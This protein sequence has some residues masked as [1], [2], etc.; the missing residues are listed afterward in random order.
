M[1]KS[2]RGISPIY[3]NFFNSMALFFN[4]LLESNGGSLTRGGAGPSG[5]EF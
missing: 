3:S 1:M 4:L 2:G 5:R